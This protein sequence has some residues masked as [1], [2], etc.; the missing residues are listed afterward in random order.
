MKDTGVCR[1][2]AA[3]GSIS[4]HSRAE[5]PK[6]LLRVT[7]PR[8]IMIPRCSR[9]YPLAMMMMMV[10]MGFFG[11]DAS[12]GNRFLIKYSPVG[13]GLAS[14]IVDS[15]DSRVLTRQQRELVDGDPKRKNEENH[16]GVVLVN[17]SR[18]SSLFTTN[19]C[20]VNA[21][22]ETV[23][24]WWVRP[25]YREWCASIVRDMV[26]SPRVASYG[27]N[28]SGSVFGGKSSGGYGDGNGRSIYYVLEESCPV[29][30]SRPEALSSVLVSIRRAELLKLSHVNDD[31]ADDDAISA[32][33]AMES[34]AVT[35]WWSSL[36]PDG[37]RSTNA[38]P[39]AQSVG[40]TM[41][42]DRRVGLYTMVRINGMEIST[43]GSQLILA[44]AYAAYPTREKDALLEHTWTSSIVFVSIANGSRRSVPLN[45]TVGIAESLAFDPSRTRLYIADFREKISRVLSAHTGGHDEETGAE[46]FAHRLQLE[47]PL[48]GDISDLS[49]T[50]EQ[51][52][53]REDLPTFTHEHIQ[54]LLRS[55]PL[56]DA[57]T[58]KVMFLNLE[59]VVSTADGCNLFTL[60]QRGLYGK[61][62]ACWIKLTSPCTDY[63]STVDTV[64]TWEGNDRWT[65]LALNE[66]DGILALYVG[67]SKGEIFELQ[68]NKSQLHNCYHFYGMGGCGDAGDSKVQWYWRK[69]FTT[70]VAVV[71]GVA[72]VALFIYRCR[73]ECRARVAPADD[74]GQGGGNND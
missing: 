31:D 13:L 5:F 61:G 9:C 10:M 62:R 28:S 12:R 14:P 39:I 37:P 8:G 70:T 74:D 58:E 11:D 63:S 67:S 30:S 66:E 23:R 15:A 45:R 25:G 24:Q 42:S 47:C 40:G 52:F 71:V 59:A 26:F 3:A 65:S 53:G 6:A 18:I 16:S 35:Y 38:T 19:R 43:S 44:T 49:S 36:A 22:T 29:D 41:L 27:G 20:V 1:G 68:I 56:Q 51:Q 17:N 21:S 60:E 72:V 34:E 50:R 46:N 73:K 2:A 32:G 55:E 57:P 7:I 69:P 48:S 4:S 64:A 33:K 54:D